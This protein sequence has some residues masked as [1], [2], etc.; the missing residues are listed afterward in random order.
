MICFLVAAACVLGTPW[1]P[2]GCRRS[3]QPTAAPAADDASR[4]MKKR[5][6]ALA[7]L[8]AERNAEAIRAFDELIDLL[9]DEPMVHANRGLIALRQSKLAEAGTHLDRAG[10]L[11]PDHPEIAVLRSLTAGYQGRDV[12]ARVILESA[13][14]AAADHLR[15]RWSL[16][17][18][19]R[20]D[21]SDAAGEA[22]L[23]HLQAICARAPENVVARLAL[24][25]QLLQRRHTL[26][27]GEQLDALDALA[28]ID[29][30]QAAQLLADSRRFAAEGGAAR[31][32][33]AVI[34]LDNVLKPT[35]PWQDSL[36]TLRGPP[37]P[38]AEPIWDFI[39]HQVP[40]PPI[41][42]RSIE[43]RYLDLGE[44]AGLPQA[45]TQT[46]V[47][48][49]QGIGT[50]PMLALGERSTLAVYRP[51]QEGLYEL[52]QRLRIGEAGTPSAILHIR[53][54]LAVD[55]NNDRRIDLLCGLAG[56]S[57]RLYLQGADG[58]FSPSPG[59]P[60]LGPLQEPAAVEL[61][62]PWDLDHDGDLDVVA[63]RRGVAAVVLR[64]NGD[65]SFSEIAAEIGLVGDDDLVLVDAAIGDLDQDG[66]LD[67]VVADARG[68][69][70]RFDNRRSG[71]FARTHGSVIPAHAL[72]LSLADFDNDGWL[73]LAVVTIDGSLIVAANRRGVEFESH[74]VANLKPPA[75]G[76]NA[77]EH[78][79]VDNDG[80]LDLLVVAGGRPHFLRN[81]G[82][83]S[84]EPQPDWLP[85]SAGRVRQTEA[86]DYDADGDLDLLV[87]RL[88][89]RCTIWV[90]DGGSVHGWQQLGLEALLKGGQRNNA[91][92][93]GG[94]IE[95]RCGR[96][97]QKRMVEGP[98]T[99]FGLGGL[100]P[101]DAVRVV[102]PNGVPQNIIAP[103]PNQRIIEKQTLKGSCPFLLADNGRGLE[104]VTDLLWR[105]PLGMKINA[106]TVA[107]VLTTRDYVK[108]EA[109]QL[110]ARAGR[111]ELAITA[112]LW[113]TMFI[114]EVELWAVDHPADLDIF[115]DERFRAPR[116]PP[117]T[118]HVIDELR[119]PRSAVDHR[120]REVL[121]VVAAR[122]GRRLGG[123]EK[124]RYQGVAEMHFVE[125]DLGPWQEPQTVLLIGSGW[126][127]PTDTSINIAR[128]Q[129]RHPP[130]VPL[131]VLVADGAGAFVE[132]IPN[133]GF[134]AGKLKTIVLD[135]TGAFPTNDHR[136]RLKTNLEIYW[137]RISFSLG[138]PAFVARPVSL[139]TA[140]AK[141]EYVGFPVMRRR[142]ELAP[143]W[144]DYTLVSRRARW[145][146]LEGYYTRYG[147]VDKLLA[148]TDD[149]FVIMNAG[150][151]ISLSFK[152]PPPPKAGWTRDFI[153]FCDGWVKD[154]DL[155][156]Q[157]SKTVG[158][159]PHHAMSG[160]PYPPHETPPTLR[161]THPDWL[162][163]HTRYVTAEPFRR[164][165]RPYDN[166]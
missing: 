4:L 163:Y 101:P 158:P 32:R 15:V 7:Y 37:V 43:V 90:N 135:L 29:S 166:R 89:D 96:A 53:R 156:T 83:L 80:W 69:I 3:G 137:D 134:P 54:L 151:R 56:G 11:A 105:S 23:A 106:Q 143:E 129:G 5:N 152:A 14:T 98:V 36:V 138:R 117:F 62:L 40:E 147:D 42:P 93:L 74:T 142:D 123:F 103:E 12:D 119:T 140:E 91:F 45:K 87:T 81:T 131:S 47:A 113:E 128:S 44:A 28:I 66:D 104:F 63:G 31:A 122:D 21:P 19:L 126:I 6:L 55:I 132:A 60:L 110:A 25:R 49:Q 144:P 146:D 79:D 34:A 39:D 161:W 72:A 88:D 57:V 76:P 97:Y 130:P 71:R 52:A 1:T 149:R 65:G 121:A 13:L 38:V 116:P 109:R 100:G 68:R 159:L 85:D 33:L 155:N 10:E 50:W 150:D 139:P 26:L 46:A 94:F 73:D 108:I 114:D 99:H 133:A 9:P 59:D 82:G 118:L 30:P 125:L 92:G 8:E 70:L 111:Y 41:G 153:L 154:G 164:Q 78:L 51:D 67:L 64:N 165:M 95:L 22:L 86:I 27:A 148:E 141:L 20:R 112:A 162:E 136:L 17:E 120:G 157:A 107:P 35:R 61:L 84:F 18:V 145:R 58:S 48:V 127:M 2:T 16:V 160:Y 115:V 102:W 75:P 77:I 124:G 24:A